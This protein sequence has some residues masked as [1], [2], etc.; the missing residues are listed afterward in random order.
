VTLVARAPVLAPALERAGRDFEVIV[1][2]PGFGSLVATILAQQVSVDAA[3]VMYRRLEETLGGEVTPGGLLK[4]DDATLRTCGFSRQKAGYARGIATALEG[5]SVELTS[6]GGVAPDQA[7]D[8]LVGLRGVG[9][10]T[11][12]CYLVF[13]LGARDVFPAGDLALLV[14]WQELTGLPERPT[15]AELRATAEGWSPHRTAAAWLLWHWY[16]AERGRGVPG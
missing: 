9:R 6:L 10:W 5:G 14:G 16:L 4:L 3:A 13:G 12:E 15:E 2:G 11:A 8:A 1:R 7:I